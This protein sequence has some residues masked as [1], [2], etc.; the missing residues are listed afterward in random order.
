MKAGTTLLET[1]I[2]FTYGSMFKTMSQKCLIFQIILLIF[3]SPECFSQFRSDDDRLR[4]TVNKDG[5]AIVTVRLAEKSEIDNLSCYVSISSV[6]G[7]IVEIVLSPLTVGWFIDQKFKYSLTGDA[8]PKGIITAA[9]ITEAME[10]ETYPSYTQYLS[11]MQAFESSWPDICDLDTIGTTNYGKLVLVLKLSDNAGTDE[12][13][14]EVLYTSTIHG[15]ETGGFVL[16]LR[17]A[18]YLLKNY[19]T[20]SRVTRLMDELEIWINPLA[21]P[22]GTYL[23]GNEI[24]S[25]VRANALGYDLN[26]NFPDPLVSNNNLQ[27][28][29]LDMIRFMRKHHFIISANFHSGEEVVNYPWDRWSRRH[30]DDNW[31]YD[32]SRKYADTVHQYSVPGY[33]TFLKDGVTNGW[34][35]YSITGGRQDYVTWELQGR[36]VTIELDMNFITPAVDLPSLWDYNWRSLL[37]YLENALYGIRGTVTDIKTGLP[38]PAKIMIPGHDRDSSLVYSDT[39][40][41][42]FSRLIEPGSWDLLV[43]ANRYTDVLVKNVVVSE[44]NQTEV[45]IE[46]IPYF[47]PI[48]TIDTP[49]IIIYPNPVNKMFRAVLPAKLFGRIKVSIYSNLGIK[50]REFSEEAIEDNPLEINISDLPDGSYSLVISSLESAA[51]STKRFVVVNH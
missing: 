1:G 15:N 9:N 48:D 37:G 27:K 28:E 47:N 5:Q 25:P 22:D 13:E 20:D 23:T 33:M 26:R 31:F 3:F 18:D 38:V 40:T 50:L 11:I 19:G 42:S 6:K 8:G 10:W 16:M 12:D 32:I 17:L 39:L 14:P 29:T 46:M 41:G 51:T 7:D 36:E 21:N 43:R 4:E 24:T 34:D 2:F 30:A 35:W 44:Y 49:E 45:N